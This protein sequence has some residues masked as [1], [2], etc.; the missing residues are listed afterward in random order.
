MS[1]RLQVLM[2][3]AELRDI[4]L[5]AGAQHMTVSEWIRQ[6]LRKQR[7]EQPGAETEK[8]IRCV[9]EAAACSYPS[10]DIGEMLEDIRRG[11][12]GSDSR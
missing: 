1:K 7:R 8:K 2:D 12:L 3:E 11:R 9:R 10:A 5:V 4:Q 6:A